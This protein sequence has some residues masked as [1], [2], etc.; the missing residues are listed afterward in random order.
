M[1]LPAVTLLSRML[2][3]GVVSAPC[4]ALPPIALTR[5]HTLSQPAQSFELA[6]NLFLEQSRT[7]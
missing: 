2:D 4:T 6:A 7:A 1:L 3:A 5:Y